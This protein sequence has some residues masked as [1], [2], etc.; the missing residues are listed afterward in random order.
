MHGIQ[1]E[2]VECAMDAAIKEDEA[3][4]KERLSEEVEREALRMERV[5]GSIVRS[6]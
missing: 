6:A 4:E 5:I 1:A 2:G 3:V